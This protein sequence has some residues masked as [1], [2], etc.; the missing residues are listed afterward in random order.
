M[1]YHKVREE[2]DEAQVT[3][4]AYNLVREN[5][6]SS[7]NCISR[8]LGVRRMLKFSGAR[9]IMMLSLCIFNSNLKN[10]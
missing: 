4:R 6:L 1:Y 3:E 7:G 10:W 9:V 5:T 2:K 8:A